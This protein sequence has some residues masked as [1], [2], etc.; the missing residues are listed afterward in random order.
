MSMCACYYDVM[1]SIVG[2]WG[3]PDPEVLKNTISE[4]PDCEVIDLDIDYGY[5][6]MGILPDAYCQIISN[7]I[8]N[9]IA[10][11]DNL[12]VIVASVGKEKC[13]SGHFA[14]LLLE[15]MGF[16]VIQTKY[17]TYQNQETITPISQ[18]NLPLEDKINLIMDGVYKENSFDIVPSEPT[19]GF[20]GVPPN[21][22]ELLKL[23]PDTTHVF[24]WTRCVEANRPADF[25]LEMMVNPDIPMVFFAQTFC[26]KM[27]LAKYLADKYN[28]LFIDVDDTV[29]KST[30]AK[31]EA[32]IKLR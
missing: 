25:E 23:F 2:F 31:V 26:A 5:S 13:D 8:N 28:G 11:K 6:D 21:D 30:R 10:L 29:N 15:D 16:N 27:Q 1:K 22:F 4:N 24:G 20:W 12:K 14:A 32:F 9:A 7:I 3:Y 19:V 17:E 18:S